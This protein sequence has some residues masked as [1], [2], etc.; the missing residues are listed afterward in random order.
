MLTHTLTATVTHTFTGTVQLPE[1]AGAGRVGVTEL[2][3]PG[4]CWAAAQADAA[5][6]SLRASLGIQASLDLFIS[7]L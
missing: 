5:L 3:G 2:E 6:S 4:R 7:A 1:P